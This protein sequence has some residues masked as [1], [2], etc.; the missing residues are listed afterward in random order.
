MVTL[1]TSTQKPYKSP[2]H[3][4]LTSDAA[5]PLAHAR[6]FILILSSDGS[7]R[8]F[9]F[10]KS[11]QPFIRTHNEP[12]TVIAVRVSNEDC[13]PVGQRDFIVAFSIL[14]LSSNAEIAPFTPLK[15]RLLPF[16][17]GPNDR[18]KLGPNTREHLFSK[19][20]DFF[21][22]PVINWAHQ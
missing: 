2:R 10:E 8:R 4:R 11:D 21:E 14:L 17:F 7:N 20:L 13:S 19:A 6:R 9:E 3:R 16:A 5:N 15:K 22:P 18:T 12:F 1:G